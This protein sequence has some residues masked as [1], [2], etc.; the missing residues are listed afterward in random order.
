MEGLLRNLP[1]LFL[2]TKK[3]T[4]NIAMIIPKVA[5]TVMSF[6]AKKLSPREAKTKVMGS[7]PKKVAMPKF[8]SFMLVKPAP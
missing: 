7:I 5:I 4:A 3:G 6:P 1:S 8:L 2:L